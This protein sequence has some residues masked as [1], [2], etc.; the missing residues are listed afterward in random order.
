M[1]KVKNFVNQKAFSCNVY[2]CSDQEGTFIVDLGYFDSEIE[3]YLKTV[4]PLQFVLQTHC[5]FDHIMGLNA[6]AEKNPQVEIYCH[7]NEVDLAYD[8]RK[9]ASLMSGIAYKPE[10]NFKILEEGQIIIGGRDIKVFYTPGHTAGSC[11]YYF[12]KEKIVFTGDTIIETSIGRTDLPTGSEAE[13]FKSLEKLKAIDFPEDT[14]FYFGHGAPLKYNQL[15]K[16]N[17]FLSK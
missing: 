3:A 15:L 6:F 10:V 7:K 16:Y 13:L 1:L 12:E 2:V 14:D 9:N 17:P 8:F 5:H 11:I 4:A